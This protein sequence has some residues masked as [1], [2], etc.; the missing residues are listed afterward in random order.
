[1]SPFLNKANE[2]TYH[3]AC[4]DTGLKM[5]ILPAVLT[6]KPLT[7]RGKTQ[8]SETAPHKLHST[9][10]YCKGHLGSKMIRDENL[11]HGFSSILLNK[12]SKWTPFPG[13]GV[14]RIFTGY[15]RLH[16]AI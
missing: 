11:Y 2:H 10:S 12:N 13:M 6:L 14:Q 9:N 7:E 8:Q 5:C 16:R 15:R 1:M 3:M 4:T